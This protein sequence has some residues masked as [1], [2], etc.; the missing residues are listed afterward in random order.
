MPSRRRPSRAALRLTAGLG[1]GLALTGCT[2]A[3]PADARPPAGT[4]V[5]P[6]APSA[7]VA[8]GT[9]S[10]SATYEAPG[11]PQQIDVTVVLTDGVVTGVRVDPAATNATSRRFQERFASAVVDQVVG[12][13]LDEVGVDRL[14]GSSST[15]AGFMA[16]LDEAVRDAPRA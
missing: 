4:R 6:V 2:I 10:G 7:P 5:V 12:R 16:A 9:Y 13:P 11:G 3:V 15:G 14:A 8:D 1:A